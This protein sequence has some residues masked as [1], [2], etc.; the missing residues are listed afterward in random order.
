MKKII[1]LIL[2]LSL[3]SL[4]IGCAPQQTLEKNYWQRIYKMVSQ[5]NYVIQT[6]DGGYIIAGSTSHNTYGGSDVYIL[7][8][9]PNGDIDWEKNIGGINGDWAKC[10]RETNDGYIVAG[11]TSSFSYYGIAQAYILK[12]THDG[13]CTWSQTYSV[14]TEYSYPNHTYANCIQLTS[15]GGYIV[16]GYINSYGTGE[17]DIYILKLK[18][19]Y[20]YDWHKI[21]GGDASDVAT[22]IQQT[23]DKG[24]IITGWKSYTKHGQDD[25]YI[26]KINKY[27]DIEWEKTFGGSGTDRS[28]CIQK[29]TDGGYIVAGSREFNGDTDMFILKLDK[30]GN[31]MW[32]DR[33]IKEGFDEALYIQQTLDEGYIVTGYVESFY[34]TSGG[35]DVY[36]RKIDKNG[37]YE[38]SQRFGKGGIDIAYCVQQTSDGGYIVS[39]ETSSFS[40]SGNLYTY[41]LK[42]NSKG[43]AGPYP[44][45]QN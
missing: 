27:G 37:K 31:V 3:L 38:W 16:A 25:I 21:Y 19:D 40:N 43:G 7:K 2:L 22:Y 20:S 36:V 14:Y 41:I 44:P 39:G 17:E 24:Y 15:D 42:L 1:F 28:Y 33:Y 10:I 6:S 8:L 18:S 29:T 12:L 30:E 9:K 34:L 23:T 26:L 5:G 32:A 4:L 13:N 35:F 11:V 45:M